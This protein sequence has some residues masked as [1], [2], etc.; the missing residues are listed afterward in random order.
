MFYGWKEKDFFF[1][2]F[3]FKSVSYAELQRLLRTSVF[4]HCSLLEGIFLPTYFFR[5]QQ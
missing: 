1:S 3:Y 4:T 5:L 2:F